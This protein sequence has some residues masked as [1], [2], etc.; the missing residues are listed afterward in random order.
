MSKLRLALIGVGIMGYGISLNLKNLGYELRLYTRNSGKITDLADAN[1]VI[2]NT[3]A[4]ACTDADVTLICLTTDDVVRKAFF[5]EG[6]L[7]KTGS[8]IIDFGTTSPE[9]T[10][11]MNLAAQK[12]DKLFIDSPMTGSKNAARDG[13]LL[14]MLG[15]SESSI[16]PYR[17]IFEAIAKKVVY[18]GETGSGQKTKIA[19]NL[20]QAEMLQAY[21]EGLI[22]AEKN[23]IDKQ[24]FYEVIMN[25][26]AASGM[27][28]FKLNHIFKGDY[29]PHF[30]L[31]NMNKDLN[32]A[33][34]LASKLN[35]HLS[36]ARSLKNVYDTGMNLCP[37]EDFCS[38]YRVNRFFNGE[39]ETF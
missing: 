16:E 7:E 2:C 33:L 37:S 27:A 23:G 13:K 30:S 9:L 8:C 26:A 28:E 11:E 18:C 10:R 17:S 4:E 15:A 12:L 22:L 21:I 39:G 34:N 1:T 29:S 32:H 19:L 35:I 20:L 6:I 38:T 36:Q 24:I 3:I 31:E 25:S 14:L 5:L